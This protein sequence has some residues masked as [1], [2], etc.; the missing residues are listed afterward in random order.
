MSTPS[1]R[2][3][4]LADAIADHLRT[5]ILEGALEPGERLLS[6][7]DLAEK[8]DVSRPSLREGL[9]K[10]VKLGLLTTSSQGATFV[11]QDVGRSFRDP[12][13]L[14]MDNPDARVDCMEFRLITEAAAAGY[15]AQR[16]SDIDRSL[17]AEHFAAMEEAHAQGDVDAIARIDADFHLAIYQASHNSVM[18][19]VMRGLEEIVRSN[20]YLNRK[21]LF[22]HRASP[23]SQLAEH[24]AI[25]DAVMARDAE[26]ASS[27]ARAH[28]MS[29]IRI[30]REIQDMERRLEASLRLLSRKDIVAPAKKRS[31]T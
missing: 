31:A 8:L 25:F 9:A 17:L 6:E 27:A 7:R 5:L 12:L 21:N 18:L 30:Q 15:A 1:I 10:L 19:H 22:E 26:A 13:R 14:L 16:A 24:R 20:I 29:T 4:K 28:M 3:A 23:D 2:P 11:S